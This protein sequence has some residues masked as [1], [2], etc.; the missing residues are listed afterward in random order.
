MDYVLEPPHGVGP[1]RLGM[2]VEE[3]KAALESLG[4]LEP[5]IEGGGYFVFLPSGLGFNVGFGAGPSRD[6]VNAIELHRP[7][8][9][10]TVRFRD[11]D[12]FALPALEVVERLRRHIDIVSSEDDD[13]FFANEVYLAL[14]RPFAADDDPDEEQGYY[15][16]SVM[17]ARPGY[18]DTP[19]QAAARLAAG[20]QPGY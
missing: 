11:V 18:D 17:I 8:S 9:A 16:Q 20:G 7:G 4:P 15:F 13:G 10:D 1:L 3:A 14:W 6:R 5:T 2:T 19:A 12:V